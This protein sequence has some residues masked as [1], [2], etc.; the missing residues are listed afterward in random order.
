M[1]G[2]ALSS[3]TSVHLSGLLQGTD[4][5]ELAALGKSCA[6]PAKLVWQTV[7]GVSVCMERHLPISLVPAPH[8]C[9]LAKSSDACT[10][11]VD[12]YFLRYATAAAAAAAA[13]TSLLLLRPRRRRSASSELEVTAV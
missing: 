2:H 3:G 5:V 6:N 1:V 7:H 13:S 9:M 11:F 12:F 10:A 4:G 8:C